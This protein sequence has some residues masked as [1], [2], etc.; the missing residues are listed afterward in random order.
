MIGRLGLAL[1]L[2][3]ST[4]AADDLADD[5]LEVAKK[6]APRSTE[7]RMREPGAFAVGAGLSILALP[8]TVVFGVSLGIAA[9]YAGLSRSVFT[10]ALRRSPDS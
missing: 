5:Q 8:A 9:N 4:A 1:F 2:A 7:T 10:T 3:A 6:P